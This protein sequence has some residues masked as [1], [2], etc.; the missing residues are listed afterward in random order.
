MTKEL[1]LVSVIV[2]AYNAE[3]FIQR[4]LN[5]ILAQ[6][7]TNIEVLVVDDGS[8]DRTAEI[9][10]SFVQKDNRVQLLQQ[11]NG[12]VASARNLAIEKSG[13]EYIAP[14]DADDIWHSRKLEKQVQRILQADSSV[15]LVYAWSVHI[16]ENDA[17][18]GTPN[19]EDYRDFQSIEGTVYPLL[20]CTNFL[21]NASV[22]L[23]RRTCFETIGDY[24][25]KLKANNAQGCEDWDLSLRIA[26]YYKFRVVP[27]FLIGYRQVSGSMSRNYRSMAKS[28]KLVIEDFRKRHPEI[29]T[30]IYNFSAS[31]SYLYLIGTSQACGDYWGTL[32][33]ICEVIKLDPVQVLTLFKYQSLT[34]LLL[35]IMLK[36]VMLWLG[37]EHDYWYQH[38]KKE[39][40]LRNSFSTSHPTDV[41][42]LQA[43]SY[44]QKSISQELLAFWW[45]WYVKIQNNLYQKDEKLELWFLSL[46][47]YQIN[48]ESRYNRVYRKRWLQVL[49]FCKTVEL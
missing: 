33:L 11:E 48:R 28:Y 16:D 36:P 18:I 47:Y 27:E 30:Y 20:A 34:K 15:G 7:Y 26:E 41:F 17:V 49:Q 25:C 8:Y 38:L 42:H 9:V 13:G 39:I 37:L 5:S 22:P 6:T 19:F 46:A 29:P 12:G 14:I 3:T 1:P 40:Q 44:K 24:N 32:R 43:E 45:K 31:N 23:I 21:S 4:T 35:K 10:K 2:P